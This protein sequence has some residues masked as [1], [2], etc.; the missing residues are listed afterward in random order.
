MQ[1]DSSGTSRGLMLPRQASQGRFMALCAPLSGMV[2]AAEA[3]PA[4]RNAAQ[5]AAAQTE[6]NDCCF[7]D[8][9]D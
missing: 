6:R 7:M 1:A 5:N 2:S 8:V 9:V 3:L 4:A